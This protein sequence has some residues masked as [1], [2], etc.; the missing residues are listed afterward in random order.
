MAA[1]PGALSMD[2]T[3]DQVIVKVTNMVSY[4]SKANQLAKKAGLDINYVTWED[5][6]RDKGS[7]W[8]SSKIHELF[9]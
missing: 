7:C 5:C 6:A 3:L 1:Q 8:G 9:C 2:L 4:D